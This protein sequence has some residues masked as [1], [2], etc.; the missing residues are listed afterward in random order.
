MDINMPGMNGKETT[1]K[2]REKIKDYLRANP[3]PVRIVANTAITF[4]QFGGLEEHG[5]DAYMHKLETRRLL[6]E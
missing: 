2:I 4:S 5:F 3:Q 6:P 1:L